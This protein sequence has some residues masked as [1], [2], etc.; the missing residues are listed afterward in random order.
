MIF[1]LLFLL[2]IILKSTNVCMYGNHFNK[3]YLSI[4][5]TN[6]IKGIFVILVVFSHSSQYFTLNG[7]YDDPYIAFTRFLGQMIVSV[8]LFYSGYGIMESLNKKKFAYIKTIPGKRFLKVLINFDIAVLL[9]LFLNMILGNHYDLK[10]I[11][12]SF[13]G[14]E[15]IGNSNWYIL[16]VLVLYILTFIAFFPMKWFDNKKYLFIYAAFFTILSIAFVYFEMKMGKQGYYYNTIILYALGMWY[17]LLKPYIDAIVLKNDMIYSAVCA[18]W[19]V[20]LYVTYIH[21]TSY[22]IESYSL[23]AIAFT[24]SVI[25][26]SMKFTF[27][28]TILSWFGTHIFSVYIL[29]RIP[30]MVLHHFGVSQ[31]HKYFF[32]ILSIVITIIIAQLFDL[33]TG[34]MW[35]KLQH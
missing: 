19:I 21:R 31:T 34:K 23:W 35:K 27:K 6:A 28:S 5:N 11:L 33:L 20:I 22:G 16:A 2:L 3:N 12:F 29:Q 4:D 9:Y 14:W 15:N 18:L 17:S 10:I 30:M 26:F 1:F 25:L 8:F 7:V 32:I 13:I 24:I